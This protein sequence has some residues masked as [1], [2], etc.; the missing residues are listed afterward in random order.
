MVIRKVYQKSIQKSILTG[1]KK[2]A[3]HRFAVLIMGQYSKHS[4]VEAVLKKSEA[5]L[6]KIE[7]RYQQLLQT[8]DIPDDLKV[9]IKDF[10]G[11]LK[12]ALDFTA[13][14]IV[15]ANFPTGNNEADFENRIIKFPIVVQKIISTIRPYE[16][17]YK[18]FNELNNKHKHITLIPQTKIEVTRTLEIS[19]N[20][21]G[22]RMS[23][24]GRIVMG[25]GA[26]VSI[27]GA[28]I[29]GNQ[30]IDVDS[31]FVVD[32]RLNVKREVWV[33]FVF[34][35]VDFPNLSTNISVLPFLKKMLQ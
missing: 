2:G 28:T 5:I 12:S 33:D 1:V 25:N 35:T 27:G 14:R 21:A 11:N 32:K 3:R 22:I 18:E 16:G 17:W 29:P 9:E 15:K 19:H 26:S 7:Q 4:D 10:L 8:K 13:Q 20:G 31:S 24:G 34:D 30:V 6:T 23:G